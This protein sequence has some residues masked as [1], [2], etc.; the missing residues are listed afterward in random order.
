MGIQIDKA[1][2]VVTGG[3]QGIGWALVQ[4]LADRGGR[5][6][7][8]GR[9]QAS[10]EQARREIS[11]SALARRIE[12]A[13]CDVTDRRQVADWLKQ[14]EQRE[15]QIDILINNAA[16]VRWADVTDMSVE[17]SELSMRVSFNG[18]LYTTKAVLPGMLARQQGHIVNISSIA[19]RIFVGGASA[20]Y[21]A[22]KAAVDAYTRALQ[23]ELRD[24]PVTATVVRIYTVGGTKFFKEHVP[25]ERM[26]AFTTLIPPLKPP[27]VADRVLTAIDN[28]QEVVTLPRYLS[29]FTYFFELF[30][31]FSRR[32]ATVGRSE[33]PDYAAVEWEYEPDS[34]DPGR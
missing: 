5:V 2:C 17:E 25:L 27:Q 21:S 28:G 10:L 34:S 22:A 15:G 31:R 3:T 20:A 6:Y 26:P 32:L 24:E 19:G 14:I 9:T 33:H 1:V 4:A 8:C 11:A 7:G 18:M 13:T 16:Y 12:L 23:A 30:P 29:L